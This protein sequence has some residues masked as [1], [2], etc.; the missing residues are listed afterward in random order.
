MK[1]MLRIHTFGRTANISLVGSPAGASK[2]VGQEERIGGL[3]D[4][5]VCHFW[6]LDVN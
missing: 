6:R 2:V 4:T 1:N 5:V 3:L